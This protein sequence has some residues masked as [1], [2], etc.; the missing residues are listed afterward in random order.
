MKVLKIVLAQVLFFKSNDHTLRGKVVSSWD[1]NH[2]APTCGWFSALSKKSVVR[3]LAKIHFHLNM[4]SVQW[5]FTSSLQTNGPRKTE[6][7]I[8]A[9]TSSLGNLMD[10]VLATNERN[11]LF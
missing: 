10:S 1:L 6:V 9:F 11:V 3:I 5:I 4:G 8:S 7:K 2:R